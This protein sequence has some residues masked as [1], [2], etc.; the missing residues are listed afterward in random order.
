M[1]FDLNILQD[2]SVTSSERELLRG[3]AQ[4]VRALA[5]S[6]ANQARKACWY[7]HNACQPE[8]PLV[9]IEEETFY[10]EIEP[11]YQCRSPL[12]LY[13]E[14]QLRR[15]L[16]VDE[17]IGDDRVIPD[18]FTVFLHTEKDIF[19]LHGQTEVLRGDIEAFPTILGPTEMRVWLPESRQVC[20]AV[21]A[22][23]GDI[24]PVVLR[25]N[26]LMWLNMPTLRLME[27]M[28]MEEY[29]YNLCD[30]P[31]EVKALMQFIVEDCL[32]VAKD[33][34][35]Q[36]LLTLN[37]GNQH[38]GASSLGFTKELPVSGPTNTD[39]R[40]GKTDVTLRDLWLNTNSQETVGISPEMYSE[41]VY[42]YYKQLCSHYGA[43][44]YGC[45]EPIHAIYEPCL[46]H[47]PNIRK[48]SISAWCDEAEAARLLRDKNIVYSR[49]PSAEFLSTTASF[50]KEGLRAYLM[51]TLQLTKGMS[52]EIIFRDVYRLNGE[53]WR[54]KQAVSLFR[55]CV[56]GL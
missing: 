38:T 17:L 10:E 19:G 14:K 43:V 3:L 39:L 47:I 20:D 16:V 53:P 27:L 51:R 45:C 55:E 36:G 9:V 46:S 48:L 54:L 56:G 28:G 34:E 40:R 2:L 52:A 35:A 7:R 4:Q 5:E 22:V 41:F 29:Y 1:N 37:C 24:L 49:K 18:E 32:R 12:A 21:E 23:I 50:D 31:D 30:Y 15:H 33:M 44:Y 13:M 26:A 11:V 8:R 6:P 42:P 25:N